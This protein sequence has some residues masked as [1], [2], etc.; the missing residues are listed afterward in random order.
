MSEVHGFGNGLDQLR[1]PAS[2]HGT[3]ASEIGQISTFDE[4]HREPGQAFVFSHLVNGDDVRVVE[5][6]R[7][8]GFAA[9]AFD[10]SFV[11]KL[12]AEQQFDGDDPIEADLTGA[13]NAAHAAAGDFSEQL[14]IAQTA[15]HFPTGG[16]W[17][18]RGFCCGRCGSAKAQQARGAVVI[19]PAGLWG[20]AHGTF[21]RIAAH[22]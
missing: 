17:G 22:G 5:A 10:E 13:V 21:C 14:V 9:K 18:V 19:Q 12:A 1:R 3:V 11:G 4:F 16:A 8:L 20:A 2:W 7:R 15:Q 6:G